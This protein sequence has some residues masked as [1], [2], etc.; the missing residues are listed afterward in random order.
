LLARWEPLAAQAA[1]CSLPA[2]YPHRE[3]AE[4][5]GLI[6]LEIPPSLLA[7]VVEVIE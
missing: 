2:I 5:G 1:R 7:L 3:N 6:G 4:A